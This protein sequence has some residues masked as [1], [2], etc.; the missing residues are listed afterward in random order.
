[1]MT[2]D[3]VSVMRT[4]IDAR[5]VITDLAGSNARSNA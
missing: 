1:M 2:V 5:P 3:T 4:R